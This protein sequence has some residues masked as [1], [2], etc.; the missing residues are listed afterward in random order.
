MLVSV[1]CSLMQQQFLQ[2]LYIITYL[3]TIYDTNYPLLYS[4]NFIC[5]CF[6]PCN[7]CIVAKRYILQQKSLNKWIGTAPLLTQFYYFQIPVLTIY[8]I[9]LPRKADFLVDFCSWTRVDNV[10]HGLLLAVLT[11]VW[12]DRTTPSLA[13]G[14]KET[15]FHSTKSR[16]SSTSNP[17]A[18]LCRIFYSQ[19]AWL[20]TK[21]CNKPKA[22]LRGLMSIWSP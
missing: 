16:H 8:S 13:H 9:K 22:V 19:P 6:N 17:L 1:Q 12:H 4:F 20:N 14:G 5:Q 7:T 21:C 3:N 10:R 2:F 18:Y 11:E 15:T